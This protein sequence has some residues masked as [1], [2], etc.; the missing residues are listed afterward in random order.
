[1]RARCPSARLLSSCRLHDWRLSFVQPHEGW[2]GGVAGIVQAAG[3]IVHGVVYALSNEDLIRLDGF[4]PVESG[5]YKRTSTHVR[6]LTD[7]TLACWIYIGDVYPDALFAP[8]VRYLETV[9]TGARE[10][11]LPEDYIDWIVRE[12]PPRDA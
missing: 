9:L 10:H 3:S 1:M 2:G 11:S 4:E 7:E 5:G 6:S 8:S 12:F